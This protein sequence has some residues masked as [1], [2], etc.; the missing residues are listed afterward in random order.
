M[1]CLRGAPPAMTNRWE[2]FR[3]RLEPL[4][5]GKCL[6]GL[7]GGADSV[8]L[9]RILLPM[10]DAG[11]IEIE[12]IHV[13]HGIRGPEADGDEAFVRKFCAENGVTL[14]TIRLDLAGREDE[15]TAREARYRAYAQV[16]REREIPTL[17]LAHQR[18]DQ[19]ETFLM[20]LIRGAG[21]AGLRA[22]RS[23]EKRNGYMLLRPMLDIS[24]EELR[25]ALAAEGI[26]WREDRTNREPRYLRNRIRLEI[27]PEMEKIAPGI[28]TR[29]ART[30]RMIGEDEDALDA[31]AERLLAENSGAGWIGTDVLR[32]EPEAIRSRMLRRWWRKN[33]PELDERE[34]SY[35]QTKRLE[36]LITAG[37]GTTVNLP[38]GWRARKR[39]GRMIL[40]PAE[41]K[42]R[43]RTES[44]RI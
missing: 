44:D 8:A 21:P 7:S 26:P 35:A 16:L 2:A 13:N 5:S 39:K 20:H 24:G 12:A 27:L 36:E 1:Q 22:M 31:R 11:E 33:G 6:I 28:R 37:P 38:A 32:A 19:A 43:P 15:N 25:E 3:Q 18:D 10:R 42:A 23:R 41:G 34:L 30:A 4:P 9:T 14:H 40:I 29:L 17:I